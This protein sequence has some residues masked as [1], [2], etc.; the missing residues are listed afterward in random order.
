MEA[1]ILDKNF[2]MTD[3]IDDFE[4]FIWTDRYNSYGDFEIKISADLRWIKVFKIGNYMWFGSSE[5]LMIIENIDITT[6]ED[7]SVLIISG[8]SLESLLMRRVIWGQTNLEGNLQN[9]IKTILVNNI[10]SPSDSNR[11][12]QNFIFQDSSDSIITSLTIK[13]AQFY[14]EY[15]YDV[16]EAFCQNKQIGFKVVLNNNK[17]FVFSLY[18]GAD[19]SYSQNL[20]P[21][22]VFSP[23]FD[24]IMNSSYLESDI[25][26]K[27]VALIS[28]EGEGAD[29]KTTIV[30]NSSG[31]ERRE[32]YINASDVSSRT[33]DGE[34]S[35]PDT[36]YLEMLK[37][38]GNEEL[39]KLIYIKTFEGEVDATRMFVY[40]KDFFM[41]DICQIVNEFG[42]EA[43]SRVGEIIFSHNEDGETTIPTFTIVTPS[44]IFIYIDGPVNN[45][46]TSA[47]RDAVQS[48]YPI[49]KYYFLLPIL[50]I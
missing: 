43:K 39:S 10:I 45:Q 40:G 12:I 28:G 41:G 32:V 3:I 25:E 16:I 2:D 5:H 23:N 42:I 4:S 34:E 27:N 31:L 30:G 49:T 18:S 37:E 13:A 24:N 22:V 44:K 26:F 17:Q 8:R 33:E 46:G 21:Y 20:N 15:V 50:E 36:T 14:G 38:R 7:G 19:R 47:F 35:I 1:Y 9:A 48:Y 6:E 29:K 11:K